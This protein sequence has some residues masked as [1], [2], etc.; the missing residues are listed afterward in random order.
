MLLNWVLAPVLV[1]NDAVPV[2]VELAATSVSV[3]VAVHVVPE[4]TARLVGKQTTAVLVVR[5]LTVMLGDEPRAV[6]EPPLVVLS[7]ADQ[8]CAP[9]AVGGAVAPD[10]LL[11]MSPYVMVMVALPARLT[12]DTVITCPDT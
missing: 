9:T 10:P 11:P 5:V 8:V 12:L 2:G 3:T 4:L 6:R 1:A 7:R